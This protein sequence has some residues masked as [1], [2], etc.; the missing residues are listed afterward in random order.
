MIWA[1]WKIPLKQVSKYLNKNIVV[2]NF[3]DNSSVTLHEIWK[4]P[5]CSIFEPW[6]WKNPCFHGWKLKRGREGSKISKNGWHHLWT[7]RLL[8]RQN[9][10]KSN[11]GFVQKSCGWKR[12]CFFL[13]LMSQASFLNGKL[14]ITFL[15]ERCQ[16]ISGKPFRCVYWRKCI[17]TEL[18]LLP[19]SN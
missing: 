10:S 18:L 7:G 11:T 17:F 13:W 6:V 1:R 12:F 16:K 5:K 9:L 3:A 8:S 14:Q 4:K 15:L 19:S 2:W